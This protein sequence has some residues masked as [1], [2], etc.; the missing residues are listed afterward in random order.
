MNL[1]DILF[2]KYLNKGG[3]TTPTG[4]IEITENGT[5]DV[6][7]YASADVDVVPTEDTW[8][9]TNGDH[10]VT[11]YDTAHVSVTPDHSGVIQLIRTDGDAPKVSIEYASDSGQYNTVS[12]TNLDATARQT[13][14]IPV[15]GGASILFRLSCITDDYRIVIDTVNSTDFDVDT[16]ATSQYTGWGGAIKYFTYFKAYDGAII[17][18][19]IEYVP[20]T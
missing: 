5:Y 8:I 14:R 4:E 16:I 20:R 7:Q 1:Y 17:Y 18:Y 10:D 2:A 15:S 19:S 9:N 6:T 12:T 3:G 11:N 13:R